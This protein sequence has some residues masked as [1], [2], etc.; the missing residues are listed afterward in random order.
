MRKIFLIVVL[1]FCFAGI[2]QLS[3]IPD[4]FAS[5]DA[6]APSLD[7]PPPV[8][9]PAPA[10][11][12]VTQPTTRTIGSPDKVFTLDEAIRGFGYGSTPI[13]PG[14]LPRLGISGEKSP[15]KIAET[16]LLKFV[17][18]PIFLLAGGVAVII[19]MYSAFRIIT[20]R[21]EEEGITA[22]KNA[23]LWAIV[24]LALVLMAYTIVRNVAQII[25]T[26]I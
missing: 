18:N 21:G 3:S 9:T 7:T 19:I 17:I 22:A 15:V 20:A 23:L 24:G 11:A 14:N 12:P 25:L 2:S 16:F 26:K 4:S 6:S 10:P 8:D 5:G 13:L 1:C